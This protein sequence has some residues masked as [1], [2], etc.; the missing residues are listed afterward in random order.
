MPRR[1]TL[2]PSHFLLP[3]VAE[4]ELPGKQVGQERTSSEEA[5]DAAGLLCPPSPPSYELLITT[6]NLLEQ[7]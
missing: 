5:G 4:I 7:R 2:L 6:Q 3:F 1:R